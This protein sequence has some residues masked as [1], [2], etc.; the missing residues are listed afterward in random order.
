MMN[1]P[2]TLDSPIAGKPP[3]EAA[4][5]VE[6]GWTQHDQTHR[7]SRHYSAEGSLR[8]CR[9]L[10]RANLMRCRQHSFEIA[11]STFLDRKIIQ[12]TRFRA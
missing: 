10:Q 11:A 6:G 12:E 8:M 3:N 5:V 9:R 2:E 4:R 1:D 7:F